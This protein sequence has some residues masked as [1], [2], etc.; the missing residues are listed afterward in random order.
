MS[1]EGLGVAL[2][3]QLHFKISPLLMFAHSLF[4]YSQFFFFFPD[5]FLSSTLNIHSF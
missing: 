4:E 5:S 1:E 3:H 2:Q